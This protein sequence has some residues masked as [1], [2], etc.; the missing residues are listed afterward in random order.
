MA[1]SDVIT[2][3]MSQIPSLKEQREALGD[4]LSGL[5]GVTRVFDR[6]PA[7]LQTAQL[8]ALLLLPEDAQYRQEYAGNLVIARNWIARLYVG[9]FGEGREFDLEAAGESYL[10]T[11][12]IALAAYPV[13]HLDDGRTFSV[14][15]VE[16]STVQRLAYND[17]VYAGVTVRFRTEISAEVGRLAW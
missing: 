8:P 6:L 4:I 3:T 5:P 17:Q 10:D 16:G 12:P 13:V 7:A 14:Y 9:Q 15:V 1:L 11:L 2:E